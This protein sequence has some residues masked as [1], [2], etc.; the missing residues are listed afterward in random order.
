MIAFALCGQRACQK[1][2]GAAELALF[3]ATSRLVNILAGAGLLLV[4]AG[5]HWHCDIRSIKSSF[6]LLLK[7]NRFNN[8]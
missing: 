4:S 6:T 1:G 3:I 5:L 8:G 7:R 2:N